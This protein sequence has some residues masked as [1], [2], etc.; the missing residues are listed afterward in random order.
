MIDFKVYREEMPSF[1][2]QKFTIRLITPVKYYEHSND[3]PKVYWK[4]DDASDS[5]LPMSIPTVEIKMV[6]V[7]VVILVPDELMLTA[8]E[9]TVV[10]YLSMKY[11]QELSKRY[12]EHISKTLG[13]ALYS[14][15]NNEFGFLAPVG[16]LMTPYERKAKSLVSM[17]PGM[18]GES[19]ACPQ[20]GCSSKYGIMDTVMHL[21]DR[22]KWK[23]ED[24]ADWLDTLDADLRLQPSNTAPVVYEGPFAKPQNVGKEKE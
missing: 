13:D 19:V 17:I 20:D 23:R 11:C 14:F 2:G 8:D 24:I 4:G 1:F 12:P 21:N 22:H 3:F 18:R 9:Y 10:N 16:D 5:S 6:D 15:L 7:A